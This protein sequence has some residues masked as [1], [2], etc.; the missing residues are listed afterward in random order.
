[1]SR[2]RSS[3]RQKRGGIQ[4][5]S[6][7]ALICGKTDVHCKEILEVG[8]LQVLFSTVSSPLEEEK[9]LARGY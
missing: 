6:R 9:A 7:T 5:R 3:S 4:G 1:M 2:S 8:N